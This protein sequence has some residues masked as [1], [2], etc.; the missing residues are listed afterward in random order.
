MFFG[1]H[2]H[3]L[4]D[5]NR[6]TL[7][8]KLREQLGEE[9]SSRAGWTGVSTSTRAP[10]GTSWS[11]RIGRSTRSRRTRERCSATS[12]PPPPCRARQAGAV[13]VIPSVLHRARGLGREVTVAGVR[14][15]LEIWDR[16][17]WAE[18]LDKRSKGAQRMLPSVL[19]TRLTTSPSSRRR[20]SSSSRARPGETVIDG[21]FG[22]GGHAWL[23]AADCTASGKLIAIDRDPTSRRT[24]TAAAR[25]RPQDAAPPRRVLDRARPARRERCRRRRDPARPR[26]LLDAARP[27]RAR[28]LVRGRRAARH[29]HGQRRPSCAR[30]TSSTRPTSASSA[31]IF[32]RYGE[33]RYARQIARAIVRRRGEQPFERTGDLVETI[34]QAIPAPARFGEGHPAKR[35]FQALRIDVND[36]LGALERALPAAVRMLRPGGRLAVI[37]FHSLEDRIVKRFLR[38]QEHGCT[39]PPDFPLCVCGAEPRC[40]TDA[41]A[42]PALAARD[43][44]QPARA[45]GAAARRGEGGTG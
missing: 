30:A 26:R 21:T 45:V 38:S 23:L 17:A 12:S 20:C 11:G 34:K 36:E 7:P 18:Q 41:A 5:K 31:L 43:R 13:V 44:A 37:S 6:L 10:I 2:E 16:A 14:D 40:A 27:A 3:S 9:S 35:V 19:Q 8:A 33:E 24:S 42:R 4:D 1:E 25:Q 39:C 28:L 15:H 32:R 22:A 29:A